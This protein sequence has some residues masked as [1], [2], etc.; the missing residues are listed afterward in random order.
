[1]PLYIIYVYKYIIYN[2]N[3]D[4]DWVQS[5]DTTQPAARGPRAARQAFY[6]V[7]RVFM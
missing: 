6:V 3:V 1:M 2:W 5:S 7:R 4:A